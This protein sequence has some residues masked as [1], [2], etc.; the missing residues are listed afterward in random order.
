M[1]S[2]SGNTGHN[3]ITCGRIC[4]HGYRIILKV[5]LKLF[6]MVTLCEGFNAGILQ[7]TAALGMSSA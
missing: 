7:G 4:F 1:L 6:A 5:H 3:V 2:L